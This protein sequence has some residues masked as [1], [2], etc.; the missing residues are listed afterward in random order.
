MRKNFIM[1]NVWAASTR[2]LAGPQRF[3][4]DQMR[5][6]CDLFWQ[7]KKGLWLRTRKSLFDGYGDYADRRSY[8]R[9]RK[10]EA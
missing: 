5:N 9:K 3:T 7:W 10:P 8:L 1:P 4:G 6:A 2:E